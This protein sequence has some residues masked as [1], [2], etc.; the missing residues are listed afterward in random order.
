MAHRAIKKQGV[1]EIQ[2]ISI[3]ETQKLLTFPKIFNNSSLKGKNRFE[4]FLFYG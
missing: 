1:T 2:K 4:T 3:A